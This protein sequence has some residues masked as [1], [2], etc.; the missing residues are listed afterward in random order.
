MPAKSDTKKRRTVVAEDLLKY[1][2]VA[3]PQISPDGT[4]VLFNKRHVGDKNDYVSNL[5]TVDAQDVPAATQPS[6]VAAGGEPRQFTSGGKDGHGRWSPDGKT[7]AFISGRDKPK[8]QIYT[9]PADGG[10]A[11]KLTNFPEG[12]LADFKWSPDGTM[13]A[14]KFREAEP[15]WTT[16]A[17]KKREETGGSTPARVIDEMYYRLDGDGY[18]N[19]QRHALYIVDV[20]TGEHRLLYDKDRIG[21]FNYDW[22]PDSKEL[23]VSG[24][25][26]REPF[27]KYWKWSIARVKVKSGKVTR[28]DKLPEGVK[29]VVAWSPDGK[30]IAYAGRAGREHWGVRNTHLF[31]CDPD[32]GNL[33]NLTDNVDYCLSAI[34]LS[35]SAE[36]V[37]EENI[38]WSPDSSRLYMQIGW[39]GETHLA[40][41]PADGGGEFTFHTKGRITG[42]FG[43]LSADGSAI[44][45][46]VADILHLAEVAVGRISDPVAASVRVAK[47]FKPKKL[48]RFNQ[49]LLDELEL[50][51]PE[52]TWIESAAGTKIHVWVMKPPGFK[53]G[54]KY[55]AIL[56]IH[57]GPHCQYG[58]AY[59]HEF[60]TFAAAGYVVVFSNPRGSK[61]YG[62]EHCFAIKG[63]WGAADWEDVQA[64]TKH[65]RELPFVDTK[66]MGVCG[67]SYGGYMTNWA[68]GHTD[69][70]A[71]AV[72][73]RCVSNLVSMVGSSDI[74][75]V[76]GEYWDG[77]SW[78][79]TAGIWAQ[80]PMKYFG[81]VK[82]PTLVIHSEGDLRCNVEQSEQVF[83]ALKL[84]GIP[85]RF[86]RYPF[87]TSHGL[88]RKG[89][90]DLRLHRLGEYLGWWERWL[91]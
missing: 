74:A 22:S 20:A 32:G 11:K 21:W 51:Q 41:V 36:A 76:P 3:D 88:S 60:Q 16:E 87:T 10:E 70:F 40:S 38:A 72:T 29:S 89:P 45:M 2:L 86:V 66:R 68:I 73:D 77:N 69:E 13:L 19:A 58:E 44:A 55:P 18:F 84:R 54:K 46:T 42:Q 61:G 47:T 81:N 53:A 8:P 64:V 75:L 37:F 71:A 62:E 63:N 9:I 43:N 82:T 78:D 24:N 85:T 1:H 5:W 35:D 15:E 30:S 83:T 56:E 26:S 67:G 12:S 7:V 33:R 59:F 34:T 91:R 17:K 79:N 31:V 80:S 4:T 48:T 27:I 28:L 14:V 57:G 50:S 23:L 39:H 49:P 65:M 6:R 25:T 52:P 90:P